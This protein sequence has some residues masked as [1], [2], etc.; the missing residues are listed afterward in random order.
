[1]LE[2]AFS[3]TPSDTDFI[4][5]PDSSRTFTLSFFPGSQRDSL[6]FLA[7]FELVYD[8]YT[9]DTIVLRGIE[10]EPLITTATKEYDFGKVRVFKSRTDSIG[11]LTNIGNASVSLQEEDIIP[12]KPFT[13]VG[14]IGRLSGR[15]SKTIYCK[16]SP[17][18]PGPASAYFYFMAN[19]KRDSILITGIGALAK[20]IVT[21]NP[22]NFGIVPS[23]T[24]RTITATLRD[25]GDFSLEIDTMKISGDTSFHILYPPNGTTPQGRFTLKPDS[26][27]PIV[28]SFYTAELM[29]R[30]HNADL[31]IYYNDG[32]TDC[33]SLEAVEEAQ[34]LQFA[35]SAIDFG[36]HRIKTH[37][38]KPGV[39][40]NGSNITLSVGAV[41]ETSASNVFTLLDTLRPVNAQSTDSVSVDFFPQVRGY[42]T[43]YLHAF[44]N[45]IKTDS[46]PI[47]GIGAAP[48]PAFSDSIVRFGIVKLNASKTLP[49]LLFDT[50]DW[51]MTVTNIQIEGQDK[52]EFTYVKKGSG[53]VTSDNI[54]QQSFS[55]YDITFTPVRTIVLHTAKM[56]FTFEDGST[57][58]VIL[59]GL[60]ESPKMVLDAD[61]INFGKVRIGLPAVSER[62][63]IIST[64]LNILTAQN[65]NLNTSAPAGTFAATDELTSQPAAGPVSVPS[66][67]FYPFS[68]S[69][70]PPSIGPFTATFVT[71]GNDFRDGTETVYISGIG[72]AP[73]IILS[74]K[75]LDY[76]SL[77]AGY[78]GTR[79]FT[80]QDTGN[81]PLTVINVAVTGPNQADF[82]LRNIPP[83]FSIA[84][85]S[86]QTFIVDF[87]ATTPYQSV[88][89]TATITFTL[90]DNSTFSV[91]LIEQDIAPL[92][93]DLA[94]DNTRARLTDYVTPCLRMRNT[95]PDS[96]NIL[97]LKGIITYNPLV[98][99]LDR[100]AISIGD[101]LIKLG[102]WTVNLN[103]ADPA[104]QISYELK[105]TGKPLSESGSLLHLKFTPHSGV[106]PGAST[107]LTHISF[108]FPLRSELS[109]LVTDGVIVIDS[110]CGNTHL[111]SGSATA[112]F[113]DQNTPNPFGKEDTHIPFDI[114]GDNTTVSIR[115]LD[116]S[117]KEVA[118]VIDNVVFNQGH[119]ITTV[120][121][122]AIPSAGTYFYEFRAGSGKPEYKKMVVN[123]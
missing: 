49:L 59:Q 57:G 111:I 120:S 67:T 5:E 14:N 73:I 27:V 21:P 23:K 56:I 122:A 76:G 46:I 119:Y 85:T 114:A 11:V 48:V 66:R 116:I 99:D 47:R 60:D 69:F 110:S 89:R 30:A 50:G 80:L 17:L 117:G 88:Q 39:F 24:L 112:N 106:V 82:T 61:S 62:V 118:K 18:V 7:Y 115:V 3:F 53:V 29:G 9:I 104:G 35:Q 107:P 92:P 81:W 79:S 34:Y 74:S 121:S 93:V 33:V 37:S 63:Q 64:S 87:K 84:E 86:Q 36:K 26:T 25:S 6:H 71:S 8:D 101:E 10:I 40:R 12:S 94:M 91:N 1:M 19:Q 44:G 95:I 100:S 15:S 52:D 28:M 31:C 77:F 42:Y 58:I 4:V 51:D 78:P 113:I 2:S 22:I 98:V 68:I 97:D 55:E 20:A 13:E 108:T 16:F 41:T 32:T 83:Q 72:A 123:K 103:S 75:T 96:L 90:D 43:G 38:V 102:N 70:K 54:A 105:G 65:I 45:N 109:P